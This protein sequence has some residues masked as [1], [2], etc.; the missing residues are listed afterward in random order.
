MTVTT[1]WSAVSGATTNGFA[2]SIIRV[3][4][5]QP[6]P[7]PAPDAVASSPHQPSSSLPQW[8]AASRAIHSNPVVWSRLHSSVRVTRPPNQALISLIGRQYVNVSTAKAEKHCSCVCWTTDGGLVVTK[9]LGGC[10]GCDFGRGP[11]VKNWELFS[12]IPV[13]FINVWQPHG[14]F[15]AAWPWRTWRGRGSTKTAL[16]RKR[17]SLPKKLLL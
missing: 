2:A 14:I 4:Q 6:L 9:Q 8:F 13:G 5:T 10:L 3:Y 12:K 11:R 17:R 1:S 15:H 7:H 16:P